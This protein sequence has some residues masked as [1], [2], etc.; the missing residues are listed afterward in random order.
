MEPI[1]KINNL[2][3]HFFTKAG[4]LKAVDGV[5]FEI[6][7]GEIVGLVGESGSGKSITG[8]SVMG[9]VDAPGKIIDGSI[10]FKGKDLSALSNDQMQN[11][12]GNRIAMIFQ[13]PMMT[14]NPVLRIE[15]QM[16]E[17]IQAHDGALAAKMHE[18]GHATHLG[19]LAFLHQMKG[20]APTL[21]NFLEVCVNVFQLPLQC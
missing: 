13:D 11:I 20:F 14:L 10:N 12:R 3:T 19:L 4:I 6:A 7:A 18:F 2:Q 9:L 15:T 5:S 17:A 1:L 8:F 21:T 16:I